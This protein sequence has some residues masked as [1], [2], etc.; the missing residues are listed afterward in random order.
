VGLTNATV[1]SATFGGVSCS[2]ITGTNVGQNDE[3][4]EIWQSDSLVQTGNAVSVS[5]N[6]SGMNAC[7]ANSIVFNNVDLD[8]PIGDVQTNTATSTS[9]SLSV[10]SNP[11][12]FVIDMIR[13]NN[14]PTIGAD[15]TLRW[16]HGG[17]GNQHRS[18]TE[19]GASTVTMSWTFTNSDVAH[20]AVSINHNPRRASVSHVVP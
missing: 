17:G 9:S 7:A 19:P 5:V 2:L 20:A 3:D 8:N 4:I 10:S 12:D 18:S 16:T 14:S 1:T 6:L 11:E 13:L 15:Q